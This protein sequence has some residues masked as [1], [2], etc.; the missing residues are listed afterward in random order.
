M[1]KKLNLLGWSQLEIGER[2]GLNQSQVSRIM[3]NADFGKTHNEIQ[4]FLEQG[5][6]MEWICSHYSIDAQ[7]AW[8]IRLQGK[9][10][11][12]RIAVRLSR[13]GWTQEEIGKVI[14]KSRN[15][16]SEIVGNVGTNIIDTSYT[17]GKTID[18]I[19]SFNDLDIQTTWSIVLE[20]KSDEGEKMSALPSSFGK[21]AYRKGKLA[22]TSLS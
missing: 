13:L 11:V 21:Y 16:I 19:A 6:T 22:R 17:E 20:G 5:Q 1:I 12:E 8:S 10:L 14:G 18:E 4:T 7:L 9:R 15:R 3:Q 2:V